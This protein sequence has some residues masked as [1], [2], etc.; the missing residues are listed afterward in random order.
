MHK[1]L[2]L[3]L[4]SFVTLSLGCGGGGDSI[5]SDANRFIGDWSGSWVQTSRDDGQPLSTKVL[6]MHI[7]YAGKQTIGTTKVEYISVSLY[8][9]GMLALTGSTQALP[10]GTWILN[11]TQ[12][13][14]DFKMLGQFIGNTASGT[15]ETDVLNPD[16]PNNWVHI[17]GTWTANR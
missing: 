4:A 10:G 12:S 14:L 2:Y 1:F 11:L 8:L 16:P 5:S 3:L 13:D 15:F 9:D 6:A 7:E 17:V